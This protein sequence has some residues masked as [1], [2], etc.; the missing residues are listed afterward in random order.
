M[1]LFLWQSVFDVGVTVLLKF[2]SLFFHTLSKVFN[3]P[4]LRDF[5][6]KLPTSVVAGKKI[7]GTNC[8]KFEKFVCCTS[9]SSLYTM[10]DSLEKLPNGSIVS[11]S[12]KFIHFPNHPQRH[13]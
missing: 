3:L 13:Q 4:I 5:A 11:K 8:D 6:A 12:C 1:F 9:C 7:L 10:N 2:L